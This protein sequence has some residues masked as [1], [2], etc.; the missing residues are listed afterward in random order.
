MTVHSGLLLLASPQFIQAP[1]QIFKMMFFRK[2]TFE[3]YIEN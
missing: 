1:P 3:L 2:V